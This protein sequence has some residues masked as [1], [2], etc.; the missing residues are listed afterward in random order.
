M[1]EPV[2][3]PEIVD[4]YEHDIDESTRISSGFASLEL[5]RTREIIER[6]LPPGSIRVLGTRSALFGL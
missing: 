4:H 6:H 3:E 2:V 1:D 5:L